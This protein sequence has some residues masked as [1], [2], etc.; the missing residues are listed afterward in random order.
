MI[1]SNH[2]TSPFE[3]PVQKIIIASHGTEMWPIKD[4]YI[5]LRAREFFAQN[6]KDKEV[7]IACPSRNISMLID[8]EHPE[9]N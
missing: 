5:Y 6:P 7:H 4:E 2:Y 9:V 1:K 3:Q 8:R